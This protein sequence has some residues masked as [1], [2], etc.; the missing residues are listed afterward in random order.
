MQLHLFS[1]VSYLLILAVGLV[2]AEEKVT[3]LDIKTTSMPL[4]CPVRTKKGD[5]IQVH[6]TGR[7]HATGVQF[8]SSHDR[9]APLPLTLGLGQVIKGWEQGLLDMCLNEKRT[10]TIPSNMAYGSRGFSSAIPPHSALVFDVEL[11]D[12]QEP[13]EHQEL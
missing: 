3:K 12:L 4:D 11:V 10:L 9:N 8:D 7:L 5:F 13:K 1:F 6:Y 2:A